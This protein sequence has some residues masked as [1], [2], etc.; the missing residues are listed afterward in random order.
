M[1]KRKEEGRQRKRRE[2]LAEC[3]GLPSRNQMPVYFVSGTRDRINLYD[4]FRNAVEASS[5][6]IIDQL[7]KNAE[8]KK[9]QE[10]KLAFWESVKDSNAGA[11]NEKMDQRWLNGM[12]CLSN[13]TR[14]FPRG[15]V[16][17]SSI[18]LRFPAPTSSAEL[19]SMSP[20]VCISTAKINDELEIHKAVVL[21]MLRKEIEEKEIMGSE[22]THP[23]EF[24]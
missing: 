19:G 12:V 17:G 9:A 1:E 22:E 10:K 11:F 16:S 8:E 24:Y 13:V 14:G 20:F 6:G 3:F 2:E 18:S 5:S 15:R 23:L 21:M 7:V 4:K